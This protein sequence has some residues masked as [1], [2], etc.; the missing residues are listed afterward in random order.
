MKEYIADKNMFDEHAQKVSDIN[1]H[2]ED[3]RYFGRLIPIDECMCDC[4][5][6]QIFKLGR[7]AERDSFYNS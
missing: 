2:Y 5:V 7:D 3:C 6:K 1:E 4:Y